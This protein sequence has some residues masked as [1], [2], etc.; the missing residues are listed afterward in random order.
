[1]GYETAS[2]YYKSFTQSIKQFFISVVFL[3]RIN[4]DE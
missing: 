4:C 2:F 3:L 1:M